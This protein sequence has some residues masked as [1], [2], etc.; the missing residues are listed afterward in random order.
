MTKFNKGYP[1]IIFSIIFSIFLMNTHLSAHT[2]N[3]GIGLAN[4][5]FGGLASIHEDKK[6]LQE[7]TISGVEARIFSV[8]YV[9]THS[10]YLNFMYGFDYMDIDIEEK[11][12]LETDGNFDLIKLKAG[13]YFTYP[14]AEENYS[15]GLNVGIPIPMLALKAIQKDLLSKSL[16][17]EL[18]N[19][20]QVNLSKSLGNS[21]S[22]LTLLHFLI[23]DI[24]M[25]ITHKIDNNYS[26]SFLNTITTMPAVVMSKHIDVFDKFI[27][28]HSIQLNMKI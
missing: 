27:L 4:P 25:A 5:F 12:Y 11:G 17:L 10:K 9:P 28:T 15:L 13:F 2:L 21:I 6:N 24:P 19:A 26:L 8:E 3:L 23:I 16:V 20:L 1:Y 18:S 14:Q 7:R 22:D